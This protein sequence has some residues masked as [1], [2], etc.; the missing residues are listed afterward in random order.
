MTS[1]PLA[2]K[3]FLRTTLYAALLL[4]FVLHNDLWQ[5]TDSSRLL[6]LPIGLTYHVAYCL[7]AMGLMALLV[8]YAWPWIPT[9][10]DSE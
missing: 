7:A 4:L 10:E 5:W 1:G 8:K 6:G 2:E 3:R 9:S